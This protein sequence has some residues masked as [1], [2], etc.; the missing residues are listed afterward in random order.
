MTKKSPHIGIVTNIF[1]NH[2]DEHRDL[3]D[4]IETKKNLLRYQGNNDFAILNSD[5]ENV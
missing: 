1:P 5:D 2:L 4:Y 3:A